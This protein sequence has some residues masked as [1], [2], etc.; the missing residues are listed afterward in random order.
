[1]RSRSAALAA[2]VMTGCMSGWSVESVILPSASGWMAVEV[3][4]RQAVKLAGSGDDGLAALLDVAAELQRKPR[5]L[6]MQR[7]DVRPGGI[8]LVDAGEAVAQQGAFHVVLRSRVAPLDAHSRQ[9]VVDAAVQAQSGAG[10]GYALGID[11]CLVAH[12]LV[13]GNGV[14]HAGLG[15]GQAELLDGG[16]QQAQGVLGRAR[17][18]DGQQRGQGRFMGC[19][20]GGDPGGQGLGGLRA[21]RLPGMKFFTDRD[22]GDGIKKRI[23]GHCRETPPNQ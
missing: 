1:M 4:L 15:A 21:P 8:V 16:V 18:V 10:H 2:K 13:G 14:E 7:L 3:V 19:K 6:L 17:Y 11:L 9:R 22:G 12:R 5:G 20:A 23:S